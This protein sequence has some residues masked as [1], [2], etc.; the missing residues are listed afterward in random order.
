VISFIF[1]DLIAL[2]LLLIYRRYYGTRVMLR[3]LLVLWAAM[4][5]AGL[6]TEAIFRGAGLV[7]T[8]RATVLDHTTFSWG[9][10]TYLDLIALV[11]L[12]AL[13]W[14]RAYWQ[15]S[16]AGGA[17]AVDPVCG[18]QVRTADAPA[19]IV[20]DTGTVH[21]C[22]DRCADKYQTDVGSAATSR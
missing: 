1:G 17:Y 3:L 21:F 12:A 6:L 19:S 2:P 20:L 22:S 10:T 7:P 5:A 9:A 4:S 14:M 13:F 11:L 18:M 8:S 16:G 15:S